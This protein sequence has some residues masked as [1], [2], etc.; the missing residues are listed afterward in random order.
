VHR[1][2]V[3]GTSVTEALEEDEIGQGDLKA[4]ISD[5]F[6]VRQCE[7]KAKNVD[8]QRR[9]AKDGGTFEI[10][11][12]QVTFACAG[13]IW[14][15]RDKGIGVFQPYRYCAKK[16]AALQGLYLVDPAGKFKQ[17]TAEHGAWGILWQ[18]A[19]RALVQF[20][21]TLGYLDAKTGTFQKLRPPQ[22]F[23]RAYG[24]RAKPCA[25]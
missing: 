14:R 25:D 10:G 24:P 23:L 7:A 21:P 17:V 15:T 9:I 19:D 2:H 22:A 12:Q 20:G 16:P 13:L 11:G 8:W 4:R 6:R 1:F 5:Y 3:S 18:T